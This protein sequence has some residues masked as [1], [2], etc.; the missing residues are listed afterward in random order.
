NGYRCFRCA[1]AAAIDQH[2]ANIAARIEDNNR[3]AV[4][5]GVLSGFKYRVEFHCT[6]CKEELDTRPG[7]FRFRL[8]PP[9]IACQKCGHAYVVKFAQRTLWL[10]RLIFKVAFLLAV[11]LR[12]P[13]LRTAIPGGVP[14]VAVQLLL[15]FGIALA[16]ATVLCVPAA[17]LSGRKKPAA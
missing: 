16:A 4:M 5:M 12:V 15:D 2:N 11:L 8:P 7:L 13:A 1:Q 17:L 14:D 9:T 6:E 3:G 10:Y